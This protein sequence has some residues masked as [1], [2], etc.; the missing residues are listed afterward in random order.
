MDE[1]QPPG[2]VHHNG[3]HLT[4]PGLTIRPGVAADLDLLVRFEAA[5]FQHAEDRFSRRRLR[6]LLANRRAPVLLAESASGPVGCGIGLI[7]QHTSGVSSRIYSV[8]VLPEA[9]GLGAGRRLAEALLAEFARAGA[10]RTYLEVRVENTAAIGLYVSLGFRQVSELPNYYAPG[11]HGLSFCRPLDLGDA[12]VG[13]L[14]PF[15]ADQAAS[16]ASGRRS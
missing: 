16:S 6:S 12:A 13:E 5:C 8:A 4:R 7:R 9:R 3:T 1:D 11:H 15:D 2:F 14:T 10:R